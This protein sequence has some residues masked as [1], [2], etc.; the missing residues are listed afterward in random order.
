MKVSALQTSMMGTP[1]TK[2]SAIRASR[3]EVSARSSM[4]AP[5][6]KPMLIPMKVQLMEILASQTTAAQA[7]QPAMRQT[8]ARSTSMKTRAKKFR[9]PA[10]GARKRLERVVPS[11]GW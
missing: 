6:T 1:L 5:L 4:G 11:P 2:T 7:I 3:T 9:V 10:S 8:S